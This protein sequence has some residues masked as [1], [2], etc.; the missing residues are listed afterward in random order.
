M[1]DKRLKS[2]TIDKPI[3]NAGFFKPGVYRTWVSAEPTDR[4]LLFTF[5]DVTGNEH[6]E[7]SYFS[8][9]HT[10]SHT[11]RRWRSSLLPDVRCQRIIDSL[12]QHALCDK[13]KGLK[14]EITVEMSD[15]YR[16]LRDAGQYCAV[17]VDGKQL[18][19]W[20]NK[21]DIVRAE[22][23]R[24]N[25]SKAYHRVAS[26]TGHVDNVDLFLGGSDV[27]TNQTTDRPKTSLPNNTNKPK[28]DGNSGPSSD[29]TEIN[30]NSNGFGNHWVKS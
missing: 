26:M 22:C 3:R 16:I 14:A 13:L 2:Q 29:N 8:D 12:T 11:E 23:R 5:T 7:V 30:T 28:Q 1:K 6:R 17:D 10:L 15:G 27:H 4:G 25:Y 9:D 18:T 19:D 20:A 21:I 24:K